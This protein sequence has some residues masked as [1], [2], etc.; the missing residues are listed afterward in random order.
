MSEGGENSNRASREQHLNG[1]STEK[2]DHSPDIKAPTR[3]STLDIPI[4]PVRTLEVTEHIRLC[5]ALGAI[6]QDEEKMASTVKYSTLPDGLYKRILR[7]R[8]KSERNFYLCSFV[9]SIC[10]VLQ[11]TPHIPLLSPPLCIPYYKGYILAW[12]LNKSPPIVYFSKISS[13]PSITT[14]TSSS[15]PRRNPD[16]PRS[17]Q[18]SK[19]YS[20]HR[21]RSRQHRQRRYHRATPQ[22]RAP[23]P[24]SKRLE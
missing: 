23:G 22:F 14:N 9:Y 13:F 3:R 16:C 12:G 4:H 11:G 10:V 7:S 15:R 19:R 5:R 2:Q 17:I 6:S 1:S 8:R 20:Y 18:R 24:V 21:T